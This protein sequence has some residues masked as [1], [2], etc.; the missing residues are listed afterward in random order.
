MTTTKTEKLAVT[1]LMRSPFKIADVI[2]NFSQNNITRA[3]KIYT[4]QP[5]ILELLIL[6]CCS[7]GETLSKKELISALWPD[8]VVGPDSLANSMARLRKALGDDAKTPIFIQTIQR[9]GYR[10]LQA[11]TLLKQSS[12]WSVRPKSVVIL[13]S[14]FV[15]ALVAIFFPSLLMQKEP[16]KFLFPDLSIKKLPGGGYEIQAGIE[17]KLTEDKKS[18]ML[19]E[20]KRITGE[21]NTGME[22][23]ID[24][25]KPNCEHI[26]KKGKNE[27]TTRCVEHKIKQ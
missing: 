18:A 19:K 8:T 24:P 7:Q 22:F 26:N 6:L 5:K 11:V 10:W 23:T 15:C 17:G 14:V 27:D 13:S 1:Q 4:L 20:I 9:K 3:G 16:E 21:E 2:V 25:I 12:T